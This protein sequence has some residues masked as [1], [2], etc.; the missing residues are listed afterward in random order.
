MKKYPKIERKIISDERINVSQ[1]DRAA[2]QKFDKVYF[3]GPRNLGYGGYYYDPKFFT[4]VVGD[5]IDHFKLNDADSVLDVGCGKG[6][7]L[8]DF[9]KANPSLNVR[10]LDISEYCYENAMPKIKPFFDV[11]SCDKL[12]YEDHSFDVVIAIATIHNLELEGVK[13]ALREIMR[14]AR[15]GAFVKVNGYR[16]QE[17]KDSLSA[18]NLVAKTILSEKEWEHLFTEVGYSYDYD[19]FRP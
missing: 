11:G 1:E 9:L 7:M 10:G 8:Y 13:N 5:F 14:V 12:P 17:Q 4:D 15:R 16:T 2:A 3:D 19:F 6:F 18:W